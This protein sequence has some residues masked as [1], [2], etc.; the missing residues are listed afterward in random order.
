MQD[1]YSKLLYGARYNSQLS[2]FWPRSFYT[3]QHDLAAVCGTVRC[4]CVR[5]GGGRHV[6]RSNLLICFP[7]IIGISKTAGKTCT[8]TG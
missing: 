4:V 7:A 8:Y 3:F 1:M 6:Y 5:G 2:D